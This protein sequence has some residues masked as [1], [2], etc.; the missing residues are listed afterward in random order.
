MAATGSREVRE[1]LGCGWPEGGLKVA[2][3]GRFFIS[4][5]I[6][7]GDLHFAKTGDMERFFFLKVAMEILEGM[8]GEE[9]CPF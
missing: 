2:G 1:M 4:Q 7:V 6:G 5:K 3:V 8:G 9:I